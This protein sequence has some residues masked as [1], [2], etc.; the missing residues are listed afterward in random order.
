MD[1]E[2]DDMLEEARNQT[3]EDVL[4]NLALN[5]PHWTIRK[6]A[7]KNP[8]LCNPSVFEKVLLREKDDYVCF[9]AYRKLRYFNPDSKLLIEPI[10]VRR[11]SDEGKLI[12]IIKNSIYKA[13]A[14]AGGKRIRLCTVYPYLVCPDRRWEVRYEAANSPILADE[15]LLT[16]IALNDYDLRVRCGAINNPNLNNEELFSYL[17]L[18]DCKY[19]VRYDAAKYIKNEDVLKQIIENDSKSSVRVSAIYN[20]NLQDRSFLE[21]L[22]LDDYD[23]NVRIAALL[24]IEDEEVLKNIFFNDGHGSVKKAVCEC[25]SDE[26][27]LNQIVN[28]RNKYS[29]ASAAGLRL[30]KLHNPDWDRVDFDKMHPVHQFEHLNTTCDSIF[31]L[32]YL[33]VLIILKDGTNLTS[34]DDVSYKREVLFVSENLSKKD[35]LTEKYKDLSSMKVIVTTEISDNV[36]SLENMFFGCFSLEHILFAPDWDV[37]NIQNMNGVF[38]ECNSLKDL[39]HLRDWDVSNVTSMNSMFE[40]CF[41]LGSIS[42]LGQWNTHN[43]CDMGHMFDDCHSLEDIHGLFNWDVKNVENMEYMFSCC[44][45]LEDISSLEFWDISNLK[46]MAHMFDGCDYLRDFTPISAWEFDKVE[47]TEA[48]FANCAIKEEEIFEIFKELESVR[49][50]DL[51]SRH[52]PLG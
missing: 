52:L 48:M 9:Y 49:Q 43:V 51:K 38:K 16:D 8:N 15:G 45:Y 3:D 37:S 31:D 23:Y 35:D 21:K 40:N 10:E 13:P 5:G 46:N 4:A 39:S 2:F 14:I 50:I 41:S 6:E 20:P 33:D 24:K 7:V 17:A 12:D 18:N 44:N 34:W 22:A 19:S 32:R 1:L 29:L 11:C 26:S 25:I 47:N 28:G 42:P 30:H 36:T 27:F